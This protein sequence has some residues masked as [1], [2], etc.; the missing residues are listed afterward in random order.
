MTTLFNEKEQ[1]LLCGATSD[2]TAIGSTNQFGSPDLDTRPPEMQRSTIP[3]WIRRCPVCGYCAPSLNQGPP[4][5]KTIITGQQ[6]R[7]QLEHPHYPEKANSFLCWAI[8][9]AE[10]GN[11]VEAGWSA[12]HAAWFCDDTKPAVAHVCRN[13]ALELF[14]C[15]KVKGVTFVQGVGAEEAV[16]A[17]LLRRSGQFDKVKPVCES[18]ISKQPIEVIVQVLTYQLAL[19]A[20]HDLGCFTI[21]QAVE[22]A[23]QA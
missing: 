13:R 12:L 15:A 4:A 2:H 18:G 9:Q 3:F 16:L 11:Y 6:Y 21:Q 20:N 17:D 19:A 22:Y 10:V 23:Q 14:E 8:I 5:A 7:Q 1:C